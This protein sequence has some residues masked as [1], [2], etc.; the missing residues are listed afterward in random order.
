PFAAAA[1]DIPDGDLSFALQWTSSLDGP[2]GTGATL[3]RALSAGT[4]TIT[5]S[6]TDRAGNTGRATV[7]F[8][9]TTA[10]VGYED[11]GYG[12]NIEVGLDKATATKAQSKLWYQDGTSW[13]TLFVQAKSEHHIHRMDLATQ[14]CVDPGVFV[15][16]RCQSRH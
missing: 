2:I 14:T 16:E 9:V 8:R 6:V 15:D 3:T 10:R 12:P 7:S 5:A 4:H 11:V 13:A 1:N